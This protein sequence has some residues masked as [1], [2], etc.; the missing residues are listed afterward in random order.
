MRR[1]FPSQRRLQ[2]HCKV[3]K[4]PTEVEAHPHGWKLNEL[5]RRHLPKR[6]MMPYE[7]KKIHRKGPG[8]LLFESWTGRFASLIVTA[9]L[10]RLCLLAT[11]TVENL[12]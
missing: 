11:E 5:L 9:S 3:V 1:C 7:L 10:Q 8:Q 2:D 12:P 4:R 6:R